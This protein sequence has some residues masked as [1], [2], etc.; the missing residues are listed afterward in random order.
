MIVT[1]D[2]ISQYSL[3]TEHPFCVCCTISNERPC[4]TLGKERICYT[5]SFA[6][7]MR[8]VIDWTAR[9]KAPKGLCNWHCKDN[10]EYGA[11]VRRSSDEPGGFV[12]HQLEFH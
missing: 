6:D 8:E 10:D 7:Y 9:E 12:A 1:R 5:V 2:V 3:P 4:I 11:I